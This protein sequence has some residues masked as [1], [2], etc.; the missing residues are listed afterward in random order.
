MALW[1]AFC[2][3][4][5]IPNFPATP[6][7]VSACLAHIASVNQSLSTVEN[8]YAALSHEQRRRGLP[9][10]TS[11]PATALLMR[12]IRHKLSR[13][14]RSVQPLTP[15]MLRHFLD[16]LYQPAHGLNGLRYPFCLCSDCLLYFEH[17]IFCEQLTFKL[18]CLS[19]S[20]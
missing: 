14:R 6:E 5:G 12:A 9:A 18:N 19:F 17:F 15:A 4:A 7:H 20:N 1:H 8:V 13:P 2:H 16:H 3:S 11:S 10:S